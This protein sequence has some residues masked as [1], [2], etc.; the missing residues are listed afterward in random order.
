M[1]MLTKDITDQ[2]RPSDQEE[3]SDRLDRL[4]EATP[5]QIPEM[6]KDIEVLLAYF[7]KDYGPEVGQV[8][9]D[10]YTAIVDILK[11]KYGGL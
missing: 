8:Y 1:T 9:T 6:R 2:V 7:E 10:V 11:E 3:L 5:K 4:Y